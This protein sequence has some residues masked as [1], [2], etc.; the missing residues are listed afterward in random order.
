MSAA[1][2]TVARQTA[3]RCLR[4]QS[5][6]A[7]SSAGAERPVVMICLSGTSMDYLDAARAAGGLT[8][9]TRLASAAGGVLALCSAVM[10]TL[11]LANMASIATGCM[12]AEHGVLG[13]FAPASAAP[14]TRLRCETILKQRADRGARVQ[15]IASRGDVAR[16]LS[17]GLPEGAVLCVDDASQAAASTGRKDG[18]AATRA[19]LDASLVAAA[20]SDVVLVCTDDALQHQFAPSSAEAL[21]L[22]AHVDE[23]VGALAA[24]GVQIGLTSDHGMAAK[25][26]YDGSPRQADLAPVLAA[27]GVPLN[28]VS[29]PVS[30][31][32]GGGGGGGAPV[33]LARIRLGERAA[34]VGPVLARQLRAV[35]GVYSVMSKAEALAA[36]GWPD[37]DFDL[38]VIA[39]NDTLLHAGQPCTRT[40][41]R[42]HGSFYEAKVPLFLTGVS[43]SEAHTRRIGL[44]K[45]RNFHLV[46]LLGLAP[47]RPDSSSRW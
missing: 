6:Q 37:G 22:M 9:M 25:T 21:A 14:A 45:A 41:L 3:A 11:T 2:R 34:S 38:L 10:P 28:A 13:A 12:P 19:A 36:L 30:T 16:C 15:L 20:H 24:R 26:R 43:L 39:D 32:A 40:G 4:F 31:G 35:R 1:L 5:F 27:H 23:T 42:S 44:G 8:H 7:S 17:A 46:E 33:P 29:V 18:S 47:E